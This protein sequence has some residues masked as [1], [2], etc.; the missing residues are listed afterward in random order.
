M[1]RLLVGKYAVLGIESLNVAGM[2]KLRHQARSIRDA[3]I[4]G[5]LRKI[6]YKADWY[7]TLIVEAD[8]FFPSSKLCSDCGYSQRGAGCG[9]RILDL[10]RSAVSA[11]TATRTPRSTCWA[12]RSRQLMNCPTNSS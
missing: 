11:T 8:R 5:L 7:G 4:G 6:R 1:S 9:R 3:A 10:L 2:D 12:W